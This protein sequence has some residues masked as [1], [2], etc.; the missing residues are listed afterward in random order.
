[1]AQN[2]TA[3]SINGYSYGDGKAEFNGVELPGVVS[4][5]FTKSQA[6]TNNYGLG[7]NPVSRSRGKIEYSGS[8]ELDFDTAKILRDEFAP[9]G[10]LTSIPAGVMVVSLERA[11]GGKEVITLTA[12]EFSGDGLDG[13]EGDENLTKSIDIIYAGFTLSSL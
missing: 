10:T 7:G 5:E 8:I 1:M 11:D 4:F 3:L 13:S 6:K 2:N 9:D 12:F